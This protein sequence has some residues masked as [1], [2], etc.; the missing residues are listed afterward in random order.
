MITFWMNWLSLK[1]EKKPEMLS[2]LF[3]INTECDAPGK[4]ILR[5]RAGVKNQLQLFPMILNN[6][7]NFEAGAS[8]RKFEEGPQEALKKEQELLER[9]KQLPDGEQKARRDKTND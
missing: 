5:K 7:K 8:K 2:M 1:A 9:L 6:I 3:S 4:S